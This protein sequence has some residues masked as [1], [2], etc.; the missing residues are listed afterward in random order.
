L[1]KESLASLFS[2]RG[3]PIPAEVVLIHAPLMTIPPEQSLPKRPFLVFSIGDS[4]EPSTWSNVP[5]FFTRT[6][7]DLGHTVYRVNIGPPRYVQLIYDRAWRTYCRLAGRSSR[8]SYLRTGRNRR[9]MHARIARALARYPGMHCVFMTY[10]FGTDDR[11]RPYTLF[12]DQ[13]FAQHIAY[14]EERAPDLLERPTVLAERKI[15]EEASLVISLFPDV[16]REL[17]R[18]HGTKVK[19]Y[20]NAV[21]I[22]TPLLDTAALLDRKLAG[23]EVAFIGSGKYREGLVRLTDAVRILNAGSFPG[24]TVN[25]IGMHRRDLPGAPGNMVFHGYLDK[26]DPKQYRNYVDIL[27]RSR[28]F[29][30]PNPKWAAFS[31]SLEALYLNTPVVIFPYDEFEHTFGKVDRVGHALD[32][33]EPHAIAEGIAS[34]LRDEECWRVRAIAAYE[35]ASEMTW[36]NYVRRWLND[37]E[38]L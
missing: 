12:C 6:L 20:G 4:R 33:E 28:L 32:S 21:N 26:G 35:A 29:V 7:E 25:V 13:T 1:A 18:Q 22:D 36:G 17:E 30:N 11:D 3:I 34:L 5:Y 31:A 9:A 14:F 16:A 24:I 23:M 38:C 2:C 27:R 8:F 15:M 37:L 19:Y 10:S